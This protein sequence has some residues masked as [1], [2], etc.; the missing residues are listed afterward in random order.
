MKAK[1]SIILIIGVIHFLSFAQDISFRKLSGSDILTSGTIF[2]ALQDR[3]GF[4]WFGTDYGLFR[5]DGREL[6]VY[7]NDPDQPT[8]I[9]DNTI[10]SLYEDRQGMIW[11]GT[12]NG[13]LNRFDPIS[14][15]F[16]SWTASPNIHPVGPGLSDNSITSILEDHEGIFWIGTY[17]G[18]LNRFDPSSQS[19]YHWFKTPAKP[20]VQN[21]LY[22]TCLFEDRFHNFWLGCYDGL[23]QAVRKGD[24]LHF[25]QWTHNPENPHSLSYNHIWSMLE[26]PVDSGRGFWV[27]TFQGVDF[28]EISSEKF[29]RHLPPPVPGDPFS[30]SISSIEEQRMN[31]A[32][33]FW[34][35]SYGGL[36]RFDPL[37]GD[38]RRW[39]YQENGLT[40]NRI[41]HVM[42]DRSNVLWIATNNGLHFFSPR[43]TKFTS[44]TVDPAIKN[45]QDPI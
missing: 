41:I 18:G 43:W 39:R 29:Y 9:S 15:Q 40:S 19:F 28:F 4:L 32:R 21:P 38:F 3:Q 13:G 45:I 1:I 33:I 42:R 7:R 35:A 31:G 26:S 25:R 5:Y 11:V 10:W 16:T 24:S 8:S 14:E 22:I 44:W 34:L 20:Y 12:A 27:G 23:Y 30:N 17:K 37:T 2:T 6:V 36:L